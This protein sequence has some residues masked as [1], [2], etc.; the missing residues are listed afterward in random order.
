MVSSLDNLLRVGRQESEGSFTGEKE[1]EE[2]RALGQKELSAE[3]EKGVRI[4]TAIYLG[5]TAC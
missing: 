4:S 2:G 5:S 1:V 3:G